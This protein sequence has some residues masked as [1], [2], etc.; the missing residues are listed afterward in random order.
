M[1]ATLTGSVY[2]IGTGETIASLQIVWKLGGETEAEAITNG[3]TVTLAG[4]DITSFCGASPYTGGTGYLLDSVALVNNSLYLPAIRV[5]ENMAVSGT[6]TGAWVNGSQ[7]T[8]TT[9]AGGYLLDFETTSLTPT[10][11]PT[12]YT[13]NNP[14]YMERITTGGPGP[15]SGSYYMKNTP[16]GGSPVGEFMRSVTF[17]S[18]GSLVF[19]RWFATSSVANAAGPQKSIFGLAGAAWV[20]YCGF[21]Q[22]ASAGGK[23]VYGGA[24]GNS[25]TL[26]SSLTVDTWYQLVA[27]LDCAT[28]TYSLELKNAAGTVLATASALTPNS[29]FAGLTTLKLYFG[30]GNVGGSAIMYYDDIVDAI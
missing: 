17:P 10:G 30:Q 6:Q 5:T 15:H 4:A 27:T 14:T 28:N 3:R 29:N 13:N 23:I 8:A 24:G 26:Y 21:L 16:T 11:A 1:Q 18:T 12:A 7:F 9:A 2:G 20:V 22:H 25:N 19:S